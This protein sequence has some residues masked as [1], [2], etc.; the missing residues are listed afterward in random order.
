MQRF[1]IGSLAL[2]LLTAC[3]G[4]GGG[5]SGSL[6]PLPG[7]SHGQSPS[8]ITTKQ[9][10]VYP[11]PEA[12]GASSVTITEYDVSEYPSTG[13]IT[14]TKDGATWWQTQ[15]STQN[16]G[17][18]YLV[19]MQGSSIDAVPMLVSDPGLLAESSMTST[20]N[21]RAWGGYYDCYCFG[22]AGGAGL[23]YATAGATQLGP[24]CGNCNIGFDIPDFSTL[25]FLTTGPDGNVWFV[26][27]ATN[28]QYQPQCGF[29]PFCYNNG[30][31]EFGY[32]SES[33]TLDQQNGQVFNLSTPFGPSSITTGPDGNMWIAIPTGPPLPWKFYRST[34]SGQIVSQMP[35]AGVFSIG[36]AVTGPDH[37]VWFT[38]PVDNVVGRVTVGGSLTTYPL[39][40]TN[41]GPYAITVGGDGAIWFTEQNTSK[42]GRI[43]TSGLVS[44][45]ATPTSSAGPGQI[46][47]PA[48]SG[49][50]NAQ[51]WFSEA[52]TGKVAEV[53]IKP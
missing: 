26:T 7:S 21:G 6:P 46:V 43:T 42:I 52:N 18:D 25:G 24:T 15:E 48:S 5:S 12:G 17:G 51:L 1:S 11:I 10:V 2:T 39:P 30:V 32:L 14:V 50:G 8:A 28:M 45:Y 20:P 27:A 4:S 29:F 19:R 22:N 36:D 9:T 49:C 33:A 34:L 40:S 38:D 31:S 37:A 23:V 16:T 44:E 47:G 13:G 35:L 41:A 53:I 3:G